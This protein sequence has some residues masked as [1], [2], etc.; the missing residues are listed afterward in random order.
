MAYKT[1]ELYDRAIELIEKNNL[2]FITDI[3]DF[4]GITPPTFY[5]H[6]PVDSN[7]FNEL[8]KMLTIN[9][10][11]IKVKMRKKWQE[12]ESATL[13]LALMKLIASND[14]RRKISQ[15]YTENKEVKEIKPTRYIDATG[16]D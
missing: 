3:I 9:T 2:F 11:T 1:D 16:N 14:E 13:Q 12:A 7:K 8:R 15:T 6:F 4:L 5:K 10:S